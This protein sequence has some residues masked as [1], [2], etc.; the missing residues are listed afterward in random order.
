MKRSL[1]LLTLALLGAGW[2]GAHANDAESEKRRQAIEAAKRRA[3]EEAL[4]QKEEAKKNEPRLMQPVLRW[5]PAEVYFEQAEVLERQGKGAEAVKMYQE[6]VRAGSGKAAKRLG[7]IYD[8]GIPGI[9]RDYKES[10]RWYNVARLLGEDV[11]K[12]PP[13]PDLFEQAAALE[14]AGKGSDAVAMYARAARAGNGK[15]ARRLFEI[16]Q[17]GIP[18]VLRDYAESLKWGDAAR[19]LGE[20]GPKAKTR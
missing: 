20:E 10:L 7:E 19:A 12:E 6:A 2:C 4:R 16:Y 13:P 8:K 9:S 14:Q 17:T 1:V 3:E 11:P 5:K 18:G 15:A